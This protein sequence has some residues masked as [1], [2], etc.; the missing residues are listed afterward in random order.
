M[1]GDRG[2]VDL[3]DVVDADRARRPDI[4]DAGGEVGEPAA[5]E[6]VIGGEGADPARAAID[7]D[8]RAH[9]ERMALDPR[10]ELLVAIVRE[11]HRPTGKEH[12]RQGDVERE[13]RMIAAAETPADMGEMC[14]DPDRPEMG[15]AEEIGHR[16][17]RFLR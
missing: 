10:L 15:P 1:H 12:R 3:G 8:A 14:V 16:L 13:D 5:V 4:G 9:P 6:D 17:G 2:D 11:P 7:A